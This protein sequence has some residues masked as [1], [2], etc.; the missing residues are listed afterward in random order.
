RER[1]RAGRE[2][3]RGEGSSPAA[4]ESAAQ[5]QPFFRC[6]SGHSRAD[7]CPRAG[8]GWRGPA[9]GLERCNSPLPGRGRLAG[10]QSNQPTERA[11]KQ[12]PWVGRVAIVKVDAANERR[13]G[14]PANVARVASSGA[15]TEGVVPREQ[16]TC[17]SESRARWDARLP[18]LAAR[19]R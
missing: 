5:T 19:S 18:K 13:C 4:A 7:P 10:R 15:E 14:Q 12:A 3:E 16:R 17:S 8:G 2:A 9:W 6:P 1:E 11:S